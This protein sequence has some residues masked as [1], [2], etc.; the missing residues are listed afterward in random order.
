MQ[1]PRFHVHF[2]PT[3]A[4]W[5]NQVEGWFGIIT[6]KAIR[7]GSFHN[8]GELTRKINDFVEHD[9]CSSGAAKPTICPGE[10]APQGIWWAGV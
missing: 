3:Y 9:N 10:R 4:S 8:V 2:T 7:R 6:Q 1:Q 5:I